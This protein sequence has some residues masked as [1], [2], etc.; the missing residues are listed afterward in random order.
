VSTADLI[1][2]ETSARAL[3]ALRGR[4]HV[5]R[6]D[7]IDAVTTAL[8]K[9]EQEYGCESPF[10][11]AVHAVL[12]GTRRGKLAEGT[13]LPP[14]VVDIREQLAA[15]GLEFSRGT[16]EV[17]LD[18]LNSA[19]VSSSRLLH[20]VRLL[21]ISGCQLTG[22]TDFLERR[23]LTRLWETWKLSWTPD[24]DATCIEAARYGTALG[25]AVAARL[26]E[27]A[28]EEEKSASRAAALL[29]EAAQ[30]GVETIS[31]TLLERLE[32]RIQHAAEFIDVAAALG[33]LLFLFCHD[34]AF[35]TANLSRVGKLLA[36]TFTRSLW[37]LESLGQS[38]GQ[39]QVLISSLRTILESFSRTE[40]RIELD[41]DEFA[42]VLDRVERDA[43]K[44]PLV[45]GAVAG[46]LWT[47]GRASAERVLS[48]MMLFS[49]PTRLGD[50]LTGLFALAREE[51]QRHEELVRAIDGLLLEFAA[52]DFQEALP[53]LRLAFTYF[54]PR[55]KHYMLTT[56]FE[57]LGMKR[58]K[59]LAELKVDE[60]VAA[61]ALAIE[62]KLFGD[63]EKYG[64][65]GNAK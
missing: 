36:E 8:L 14:L 41:R 39:D 40:S 10:L 30:A 17:E 16:R 9:D 45:R 11:D 37:L 22:G 65:E 48:E 4:P 42:V 46:M 50:Y 51:V 23:D 62:E 31:A 15:A 2:V 18:L 1:A 58:L 21:G 53:S 29:V 55:E 56:L 28:S 61:R 33:H 13:R 19:D 54:T 34:E 6:R 27:L 3:A 64:L 49:N 20:R 5:W 43:D 52:D 44:P 35:G 60:S 47:I 32:S 63:I 57:S 7:L 25:E 26:V 24:F 59:P 12:R 38:T